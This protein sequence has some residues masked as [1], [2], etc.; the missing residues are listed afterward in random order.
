M[1]NLIKGDPAAS[2]TKVIFVASVSQWGPVRQ[3]EGVSIDGSLVKPVRQSQLLN[4]LAT[5]WFRKLRTSAEEPTQPR[6]RSPAAGEFAGRGIRVLVAEDNVVNQK[7]AGLM[8][9][10]LG[11]RADFAAD[12]R[13]A[14][15]MTAMAPYDLVFMDCQMPQLDGYEAS[16]EIRRRERPAEHLVI[17]AMTAD[18][19]AGARENCMA[20]GMD[21]Y[22]TKPVNPGELLR[23]LE[24]WVP[25]A[26]VARIEQPQ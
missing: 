14:V 18:A 19:I 4:I 22:I 15:Q 3:M 10:R 20:A 12:G 24:K 9:D 6:R 26:K 11:L 23:I 17:I 16:R 7:V 25:A 1:A 2:L 5:V 21:D 13:E 8:L